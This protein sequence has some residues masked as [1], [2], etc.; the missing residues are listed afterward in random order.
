MVLLYGLEGK[1][2]LI[3]LWSTLIGIGVDLFVVDFLIV[4]L[5]KSVFLRKW[6]AVRGYYFDYD[7]QDKWDDKMKDL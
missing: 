7:F 5:G 3:P 2:S 1:D 4:L 6:F